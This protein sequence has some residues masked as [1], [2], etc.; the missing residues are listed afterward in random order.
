MRARLRVVSFLSEGR[1]RLVTLVCPDEIMG[2]DE[3]VPPFNVDRRYSLPV[4]LPK[5]MFSTNTSLGWEMA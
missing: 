2:R 3:L 5:V 4:K 1:A